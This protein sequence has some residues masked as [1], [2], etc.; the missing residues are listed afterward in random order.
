IAC[1][2][3]L[4]FYCYVHSL[5]IRRPPRS[6]LF[7]YTTL[8]RSGG[9][10]WRNKDAGAWT[11]PKGE[12]SDSEELQTTALREFAEET[13]THLPDPELVR[14]EERRVGKVIARG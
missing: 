2:L 4:R 12:C 14:S 5:M 1:H 8:F 3:I 13:G 6:T 7:P 10:F 11:I 9:P